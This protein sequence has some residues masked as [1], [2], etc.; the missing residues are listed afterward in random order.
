M[1]LAGARKVYIPIN[2]QSGGVGTHW[3]RVCVADV[4]K[5]VTTKRGC[6]MG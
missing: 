4:E 1:G 6:V 2:H 5:K 3:I